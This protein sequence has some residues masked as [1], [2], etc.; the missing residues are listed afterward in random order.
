[1]D[2][3]NKIINL[4]RQEGGAD[5]APFILL[6]EVLSVSP[7]LV[8]VNNVQLDK[9]NLYI[10]DDLITSHSHTYS[11]GTTSEYNPTL[12]AGDRVAI[13]PTQDKKTFI[14]LNKVVKPS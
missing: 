6:G 2:S 5:I 1:M 9:D 13:M 14:I 4:I 3:Y 10:S 7:L 11:G 12:Q 8:L